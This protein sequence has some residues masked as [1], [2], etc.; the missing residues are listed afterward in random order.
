MEKVL[1]RFEEKDFYNSAVS[2]IE[3]YINEN[4][5]ATELI[6]DKMERF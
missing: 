1:F 3:S 6:L 5:Q 4:S 2:H